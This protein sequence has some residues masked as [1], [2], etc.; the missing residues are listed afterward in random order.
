[1]VNVP[2]SNGMVASVIPA[3]G[4]SGTTASPTVYQR[5]SMRQTV[6]RHRRARRQ[7]TSPQT[8]NGRAISL[9]GR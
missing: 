2:A 3:T 1:M 5:R 9:A 7:P 8:C 4:A 6:T